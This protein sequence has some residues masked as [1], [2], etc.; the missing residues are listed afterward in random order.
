MKY[1][2]RRA[3]VVR[4]FSPRRFSREVHVDCGEFCAFRFLYSLE[5]PGSRFRILADAQQ[6]D[7]VLERSVKKPRGCHPL[8]PRLQRRG[9]A[10]RCLHSHTPVA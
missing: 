8:D 9:T 7:R 2:P 6:I 4:S 3:A 10:V 5:S 1:R